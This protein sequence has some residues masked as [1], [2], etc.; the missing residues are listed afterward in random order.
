M[1]IG[2]TTP[3]EPHFLHPILNAP[4]PPL[5]P[6][7]GEGFDRSQGL[8]QSAR[9]RSK[10]DSWAGCGK[11]SRCKAHEIPRGEAYIE[12]TSQRRGMSVMQPFGFAS[13]P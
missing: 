2:W 6:T 7:G 1:K 3:L 11:M 9:M 10:A 8:S 13:R 12:S 4:S 5:S